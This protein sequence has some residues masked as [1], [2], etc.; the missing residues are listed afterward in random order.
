MAQKRNVKGND[1]GWRNL[2]RFASRLQ[3]LE[4]EL[5]IHQEMVKILVEEV[6]PPTWIEVDV[7]DI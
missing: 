2:R 5:R 4:Q 6:P 7:S 1:R 3:E